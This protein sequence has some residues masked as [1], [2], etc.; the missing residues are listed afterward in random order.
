MARF[1]SCDASGPL[2]ESLV[3]PFT[4]IGHDWMLI[5]AGSGTS[6]NEWNAMT[7]SW[8][9]FGVHWNRRTVSCVIRPTRHTF[10]FA[11][12]EPLLTFSFFGPEHKK[13]LQICGSVSG[14][15]TDKAEAAGI[16]PVVLE[17]GAVGF[18]QA[19]LSLVCR[20][21]YAQDMSPACFIDKSLDSFYELK[22]YHRM[23]ICEILRC[24][25]PAAGNDEARTAK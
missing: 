1:A 18:S 22:D 7:A 12:R 25:T 11:E 15:D 9:G 21:I 14:R 4:S 6:R 23:Y 24:W 10:P 3:Q 19:R 17:P 5:S 16:E 8:G 2:L 20:K 13:A